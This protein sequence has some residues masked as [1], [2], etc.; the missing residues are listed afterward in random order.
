M[1][2]DFKFKF[3]QVKKSAKSDG[4]DIDMSIKFDG[5]EKLGKRFSKAQMFLD[6]Q[7]LKDTEPFVP[8]D[9]NILIASGVTHTDY[10]SGEVKWKTPY[11]EKQYYETRPTRPY[12]AQRGSKWF[13]RSKA[14]Y[15]K[16]W[17]EQAGKVIGGDGE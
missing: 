5:H 15:A 16:Q 9:K 8:K 1:A 6:S 7:V 17:A 4:A 12:D 10:G 2:I 11:A 3:N 13:E 14:M